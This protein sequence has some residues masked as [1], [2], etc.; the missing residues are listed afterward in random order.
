MKLGNRIRIRTTGVLAAVAMVFA[1]VVTAVSPAAASTSVYASPTGSGV[2]C[3]LATPCSLATG[4]ATV[5]PNSKLILASGTYTIN[6][7]LTIS[8]SNI[9]IEGANGAATATTIIQPATEVLNGTRALSGV[10]MYAVISVLPGTTN[11]TFKNF[12]VENSPTLPAC[13]GNDFALIMFQ[14]AS[15]SLSHVYET[16]GY[17][18]GGLTGCQEGDNIYVGT[19]P[20]FASNVSIS[21]VHDTQYNKNGITCNGVGTT[22][23]IKS[24]TVTSTP[25]PATA[26]NAVQFGFGGGGSVKSSHISGNSYTGANCP[27]PGCASG[28][29]VYQGANG[30]QVSQNTLTGNDNQI[31]A[32]SGGGA[33]QDSANIIIS[34]NK[35]SN[36]PFFGDGIS[37]V[38]TTG[39]NVSGNTTQKNAEY[40]IGVFGGSGNNIHGNFHVLK[41]A[42]GGIVLVGSNG[43]TV[44]S[45]T[46]TYNTGPGI[47]A[48]SA[49]T[50][51]SFTSN[52]MNHNNPDGLDQSTGAGTAGTGNTWTSNTCLNRSPTGIC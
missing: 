12:T 8:K 5:G 44:S 13:D 50:G 27:G 39:A 17:P 6:S 24:A 43:N 18:A 23:T 21:S 40:G 19:D 4:Y 14:N 15:G 16:A 29:L 30:I 48:D 33:G 38:G 2:V 11:V 37:L 42:L 49:S 34:A 52:I 22:C 7:Q 35:S 1:F 20:T 46:V 36:A 28:I 45:N 10:P 32:Y 25:T 26:Q 51:N 47:W 3:S 31:A 41:N 9:T